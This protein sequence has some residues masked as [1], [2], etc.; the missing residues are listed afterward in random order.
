M[1]ANFVFDRRNY[2]QKT[3]NFNFVLV[4][5]R[6]FLDFREYLSEKHF[7]EAT[8]ENREDETGNSQENNSRLWQTAYK[9]ICARLLTIKAE[10]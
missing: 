1:R 3:F 10:F 7:I 5:H 8:F 6:A 9:A 2:E 4:I